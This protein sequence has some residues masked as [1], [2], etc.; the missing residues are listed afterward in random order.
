[1]SALAH[2]LK[3]MGYNVAGSDINDHVYT[4]D[5]LIKKGIEIHSFGDCDFEDI[6]VV[7]YGHSFDLDFFEIKNAMN[8]GIKVI[9]Y[10]KFLASLL[11]NKYSIAIAGSH[12]KTNSVGL[13]VDMMKEYNPSFLRGDGLGKWTD[14]KYFIF[15]ACEY[16]NHFLEYFPDEAIILNVDYDHTDY[17]KTLSSYRDSFVRF[18][19][20]VKNKVYAHESVYF[21]KNDVCKFGTKEN[22]LNGDFHYKDIVIRNID[23]NV[24]QVELINNRLGLITC[25]LDKN[26]NIENIKE[27]LIKYEGAKRRFQESVVESNIIIDDYAHHPCQMK[28]VINEI[29]EK[30]QNKKI[31]VFYKPDRYSRLFEFKDEIKKALSIAC[32]AYVINFNK[33][34]KNDTNVDFD[35]SILGFP[36][37]DEL[38]MNRFS[39]YENTIFL[40]ISSKD[41]SLYISS[42]TRHLAVK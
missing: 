35:V 1:M 13:L 18:S 22:M 19:E 28:V 36:V 17:F 29:K 42:L 38:Y 41:M 9:E 31:V 27:S 37:I 6:D 21:I 11:E 23:F 25:A 26:T 7:I 15:E 8:R 4:E 34:V 10:N 16:K 20:Q 39:Q 12:G 40:F 14:S 30:C 33:N 24:N 2:I 3:D 5:E 32:E